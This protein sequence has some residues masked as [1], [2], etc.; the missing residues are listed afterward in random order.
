MFNEIKKKHNIDKHFVPSP[1]AVVLSYPHKSQMQDHD[2]YAN[3]WSNKF[4][5]EAIKPTYKF[6][7]SRSAK[8]N[9]LRF[10]LFYFMDNDFATQTTAIMSYWIETEIGAEYSQRPATSDQAATLSW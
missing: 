3:S 9:T 6:E 1:I 8:S 7:K 5:A 10:W 4:R 2:H